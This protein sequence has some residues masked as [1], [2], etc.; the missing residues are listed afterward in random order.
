MI[1]NINKSFILL[2]LVSTLSFCLADKVALEADL[3]GTISKIEDNLGEKIFKIEFGQDINGKSEIIAI[4][5]DRGDILN[6]EEIEELLVR[7]PVFRGTEPP[8]P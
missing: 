6:R 8:G 4:E 7:N 3:E 2:V 1:K 5:T